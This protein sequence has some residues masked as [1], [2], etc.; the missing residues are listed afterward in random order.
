MIV[1]DGPK[2]AVTSVNKR[3]NSHLEF[4][5]C[6]QVEGESRQTVRYICLNSGSDPNCDDML[7]G[8]IEGT[9]LKMPDNCGPG[10]HAVAHKVHVASNQ[11]HPGHLP[12]L[13]GPVMELTFDY[14]FGLV[15]R[16]AGDIYFRVDNSSV[17][18]Y[19][20][21]VVDEPR[22]L[23]K[24]DA[25]QKRGFGK[26][27]WWKGKYSS[28]RNSKAGVR[29]LETSY[30]REVYAE[31]KKCSGHK[32]AYLDIK[33]TVSAKVEANWGSTLIGK[34]SPWIV[35]EAYIFSDANTKVGLDYDVSA[36]GLVS[37][38]NNVGFP[39]QRTALSMYESRHPG[40]GRFRP[41]F[42][43][44]VGVTPNVEMEG[45][46]T[47]SYQATTAGSLN[48]GY[49]SSGLGSPTG[50]G[51]MNPKGIPFNGAIKSAS[52]GGLKI[53]TTTQTGLEIVFNKYGNSGEFLGLN[54]TGTTDTY[55][56]VQVEDNKYPISAGSDEASAGLIYANGGTETIAAWSPDSSATIL[57]G[58]RLGAKQVASGSPDDDKDPSKGPS[59]HY[60][61]YDGDA[62]LA[63]SYN[64][65]TPIGCIEHV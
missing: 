40:I 31:R 21:D 5:D 47:I 6:N 62:V 26:D 29:T 33:A 30:S 54:I 53:R 24:R 60:I 63:N 45:N 3:D 39:L 11:T 10:T 13:I 57:L 41:W 50:Y 28:L 9:I 51:V 14:N 4:L 43:A 15:K 2:F 1:I 65:L 59:P 19:W 23:K 20:F 27:F 18:E 44:D 32:D 22:V 52:T 7:I 34:I 48:Q 58:D 17:P 36:K 25:T 56:A 8:G 42:N 55:A 49:P 46:F 16:D 35:S 61:E 64:N 37:S 12:E 38:D